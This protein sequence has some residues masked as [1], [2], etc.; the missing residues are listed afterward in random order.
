MHEALFNLP[1]PASWHMPDSI[2]CCNYSIANLF[3]QWWAGVPAPTQGMLVSNPYYEVMSVGNVWL[4]EDLLCGLAKFSNGVSTH[5]PSSLRHSGL[6]GTSTGVHAAGACTHTSSSCAPTCHVVGAALRKFLKR[7]GRPLVWAD[8]GAADGVT[9]IDPVVGGIAGMRTAQQDIAV[10]E[11][12]WANASASNSNPE[13]QS[14]AFLALAAA[15]PPNQ[16]L[17]LPSWTTKDA[18]AKQEKDATNMIM[19]T[20]GNGDC[21]CWILPQ[22]IG[23]EMLND[24]TC[25]ESSTVSVQ[26]TN[27]VGLNCSLQLVSREPM[28]N[29]KWLTLFG[30]ISQHATRACNKH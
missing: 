17:F 9:L 4:P 12:F 10:W 24:G 21:V 8:G 22:P 2:K 6:W 7:A 28:V 13:Q 30:F 14:A 16:K 5:A 20:D 15:A 19:G 25:E 23:C 29:L 11:A 3:N 27:G 26:S 1:H 18:C